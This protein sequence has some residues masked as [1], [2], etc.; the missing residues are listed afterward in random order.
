MQSNNQ[1]RNK[2]NPALRRLSPLEK[3]Q[4]RDMISSKVEVKY[5]TIGSPSTQI[6][7][8]GSFLKDLSLIGQGVT[9]DTRV[10]DDLQLLEL[11]VKYKVTCSTGGLFT[12]ADSYNTVRVLI[13]RWWQDDNTVAPTLSAVLRLATGCTDYTVSTYNKDNQASFTMLH[14]KT[15]LVYNSPVYNGTNVVVEAGAGHLAL[16]D[17]SVKGKA[18]GA[19]TI[20]YTNNANLGIG[21][22]FMMAVSDSA[23][24][25]HCTLTLQ[26]ITQFTDA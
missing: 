15:H 5:A 2:N 6:D 9:R 12:A 25:P 10:G 11:D 20:N 24:S 13:F 17:V 18:L 1:L 8:A 3:R 19:K 7:N 21:K 14:D 22:I 23:F 4:I 26:S 16:Q